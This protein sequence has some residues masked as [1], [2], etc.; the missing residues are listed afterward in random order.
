MFCP[1]IIFIN[2]N[3][4]DHSRRVFE[5]LRLAKPWQIF[6]VADGPRTNVASD[7]EKCS[8]VREI[9]SNVDW[10]CNV[11]KNFSETN[12]GARHRIESGINWAFTFDTV[13][14]VIILED[15][16]LPELSFFRYCGELL[17]AYAL[18]ERVMAISGNHFLPVEL[19]PSSSYYFVRSPLIWGWATWKRAWKLFPQNLKENSL[20]GL[21][22]ALPKHKRKFC[23]A[24]EYNLLKSKLKQ[25]EKGQLEA[26]DYI[27]NVIIKI[28][29]GLCICPN[30]NLIANI[31][32]DEQATHTNASFEKDIFTQTEEMRFPLKSPQKIEN[33]SLRD[34]YLYQNYIHVSYWQRWKDV[35][36]R[37]IHY[38]RLKNYWQRYF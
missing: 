25:I 9:I 20:C 10:E 29:E 31:G 15:D 8:A 19:S 36:A 2:F 38:R 3:R 17:K 7:N 6:L 21:L 28:Q 34:L 5:R 23:S 18:E 4:P 14:Y 33:D 22:K 32:F 12:M 13:E 37:I 16:C 26:W 27:W 35:I 24:G 11:H 30:V 1:P